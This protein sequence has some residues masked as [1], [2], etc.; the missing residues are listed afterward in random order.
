MNLGDQPAFPTR[1]TGKLSD[2]GEWLP[3]VSKGMSTRTWLAAEIA[4]ALV[5]ANHKEQNFEHYLPSHQGDEAAFDSWIAARATEM[6][7][8]LLKE[9]EKEKSCPTT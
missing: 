6:T 4:T 9:L 1:I 7:G 8:T 3:D 2:S 5:I